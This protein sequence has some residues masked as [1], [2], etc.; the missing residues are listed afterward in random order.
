MCISSKT[1]TNHGAGLLIQHF[2]MKVLPHFSSHCRVSGR[3]NSSPRVNSCYWFLLPFS[4]KGWLKVW[5]L[6]YP[7]VE[8]RWDESGYQP[9]FLLKEGVGFIGVSL[10][11]KDQFCSQA[12]HQFSACLG[13]REI[14][15][16]PPPPLGLMIHSCLPARG[17]E[18]SGLGQSRER[19]KIYGGGQV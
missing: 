17:L 4:H 7:G 16:N 10:R 11:S 19:E 9:S 13:G 8:R 6:V 15:P 1:K 18:S 14:S 5:S 12:A 3:R 2:Y